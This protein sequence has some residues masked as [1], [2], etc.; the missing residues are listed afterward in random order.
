MT[1][2]IARTL[3]K[4]INMVLNKRHGEYRVNFKQKDGGN[5]DSAYYTDQIEDAVL[6]AQEM[7]RRKF[8]R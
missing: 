3:L 8:L 2:A 7:Y 4:P 5:E 1:L 6:T